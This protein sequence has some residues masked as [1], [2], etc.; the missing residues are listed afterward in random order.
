M[1]T[2]LE[3][4]RATY[5]SQ[6]RLHPH[7][8]NIWISKSLARRWAGASLQRVL[9]HLRKLEKEFRYEI[10]LEAVWHPSVLLCIILHRL[11]ILYSYSHLFVFIG[12]TLPFF[13]VLYVA[14]LTFL[15]NFLILSS[16]TSCILFFFRRLHIYPHIVRFVDPTL[17]YSSSSYAFLLHILSQSSFFSFL[18]VFVLFPVV[19]FFPLFLNVVT[20]LVSPFLFHPLVSLPY[21]ALTFIVVLLPPFSYFSLLYSYS[22]L[23]PF[24]TSTTAAK[25]NT[26]R[27]LQ[28]RTWIT[29]FCCWQAT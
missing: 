27:T 21:A 19:F 1:N 23:F 24:T 14:V 22:S 11:I 2:K 3:L 28:P 15:C 26:T 4:W 17:N 16:A 13:F 8:M 12:F 5:I 7:F 18:F 25:G 6:W 20:F 9:Q 29:L 10:W